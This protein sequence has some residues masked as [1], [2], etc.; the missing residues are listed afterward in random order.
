MRRIYPWLATACLGALLAGCA[1]SR[2]GNDDDGDDTADG[3]ALVDGSP[4][5][6]ADAQIFADATPLVSGPVDV[7]ITADNAYSFGYG[8]VNHIATYVQGTRAHTAGEIFNCPCGEGPQSDVGPEHYTVAEADAPAGAYLYIVSWDDLSVTQGVLGQFKRQ[9][10][11]VY[12]GFDKFQ[13]CATGI[14]LSGSTVGPTQDEVNAQI[15]ICDAGSGAAATTSKGWV[16]LDAAVTAGA[17]GRLAVGEDNGTQDGTFPI[18]CQDDTAFPGGLG[19]GIDA[20][21]HWMWYDP[22][23][24]GGD[25]FHS[26]GTNQYKAYLIFRLPADQIVID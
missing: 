22:E 1:P 23:G 9:G 2:D 6:F 20:A 24:L 21:A 7:V 12:T 13:V 8:D 3:G 18:T 17:T 14:D 4:Q 11:T 10:A 15:A 19:T 26:N 16:S 25:S 5:G